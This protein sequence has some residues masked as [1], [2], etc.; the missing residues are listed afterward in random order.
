MGMGRR[1]GEERAIQGGCLRSMDQYAHV[2]PTP[3]HVEAP[4]VL[5]EHEDVHLVALDGR[6]L[7]SGDARHLAHHMS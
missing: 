5:P 7:T 1:T 6:V 3:R 4:L 2:R